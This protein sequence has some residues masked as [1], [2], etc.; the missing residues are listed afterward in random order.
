MICS[1]ILLCIL[2]VFAPLTALCKS[3][4]RI[5]VLSSYHPAFPTFFQQIK[6]ITSA[7]D[8]HSTVFDIECMDS[9]RFPDPNVQTLVVRLLRE[10]LVHS[11][12]YDLIITTDDN[13]FTFA[14][15]YHTI[16]L[17]GKPL[18]FIGVN[19]H[20][21]A[22]Q[23]NRNAS[24]TGLIE[25]ISMRET[26]KLM[27][28]LHPKIST[29]FAIVDDTPSG[30]N[31]LKRLHTVAATFPHL[32]ISELDVSRMSFAELDT[33]LAEL[34]NGTGVLLLSAYRDKQ[35]KKLLF[36]ESLQQI[37]AHLKRPLYH[38]WYQGIGDGILG[39]KVINQEEQGR[40]GGALARAILNGQSP[41]DFPVVETSSNAYVFD[42]R[43]LVR[44]GISM[45]Q[46]PPGSTVL[47]TPTPFLKRYVHIIWALLAMLL[48]VSIILFAVIR[49]LRKRTFLEKSLKANEKRFTHLFQ[50]APLAY[51]AVDS[52]ATVTQVNQAWLTLAEHPLENVLA[53]PLTDFLSP[54]SRDL[55]LE[56]FPESMKQRR[57][58]HVEYELMTSTGHHLLCAVDASMT[59]LDDQGPFQAHLIFQDVTPQKKNERLLTMQNDIASVF[60]RTPE[61]RLFDHLL[62]VILTYLDCP[63]GA[64]GFIDA[65]KNLV[66]AAVSDTRNSEGPDIHPGMIFEPTVWNPMV[67]KA[68]TTGASLHCNLDTTFFQDSIHLSS[69]LITPIPQG[70]TSL[71]LFIVGDKKQGF[72]RDDNALLGTLAIRFAPLLRARREAMQHEIERSQFMPA[73]EQSDRAIMILDIQGRIKYANPATQKTGYSND[74]LIGMNF[75]TLLGSHNNPDRMEHALKIV[76][77]GRTWRAVMHTTKKDGTPYRIECSLVPVRQTSGDISQALVLFRDI[78]REY[79]LERQL[80]QAQKMEAVGRLAGGIAHDFNNLLQVIQGY[81]NLLLERLPQDDPAHE[82]LQSIH[83]AADRAGKL[84]SQLLTFSRK[85]QSTSEYIDLNHLISNLQSMLI[86]IIGENILFSLEPSHEQLIIHGNSGQIEQSLVNLCINARDAMPNGGQLLLTTGATILDAG[87]CSENPWATPGSYAQITIKD[88]GSGIDPDIQDKIFEPFFTTKATGK[89]TGLGLAMVYGIIE[90]H[91]GRIHVTSQKEKGTTISIYLP[92]QEGAQTSLPVDKEEA[93]PLDN[94][95]NETILLAED[96]AM[97]R[98]LTRTVLEEA[99]YHVIEASNGKEAVEAFTAHSHDI[100]LVLLDV[101]MPELSGLGVYKAIKAKCAGIP[102]VFSSGYSRDILGE[103]EEVLDTYQ[104]LTKPY[105]PSVLLQTVKTILHR[106]AS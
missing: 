52:T 38:L 10:K 29:V 62:E 57:L 5:L 19:N 31:S 83:Q 69:V 59:A 88:T 20:S 70:K 105:H 95:G 74:E 36:N 67:T 56:H 32:K 61:P 71:G 47:N 4:A 34:G 25:D 104:M 26:L 24:V 103:D 16:L 1:Q 3:P 91:Q 14:L 76:Y 17:H 15:K 53:H 37:T 35:G 28:T 66:M 87:Y 11:K 100:D 9:K 43:Q 73:I 68:C 58:R 48:L 90:Q 65:E 94:R 89:G 51:V 41:A 23:Q 7:F 50:H 96:E 54:A 78:T 98:D 75:R 97:V 60:L 13:A 39:G 93:A 86:R 84:V 49:T 6:G 27:C 85:K 102:I 30:R 33:R 55:F 82:R 79:E 8:D 77:S 12:P 106:E 101:V 40:R 46:L 45:S 81:G 22:L 72:S 21:L 92:L 18:V 64:V 80:Q 2:A 42:Y 63:F 99:G 44:F